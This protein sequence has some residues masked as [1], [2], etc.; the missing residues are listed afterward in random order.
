MFAAF[1]DTYFSCVKRKQK[2][3]KHACLIH[4]V[5]HILVALKEKNIYKTR[6]FIP[7]RDKNFPALKEKKNM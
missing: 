5:I 6:M 2:H 4:F 3:V 7:F 1:R